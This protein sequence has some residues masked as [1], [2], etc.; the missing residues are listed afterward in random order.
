MA[1]II[2]KGT[3]LLTMFVAVVCIFV[4]FRSLYIWVG[5]VFC[6]C[7]RCIYGGA[8]SRSAL[9]VYILYK[10]KNNDDNIDDDILNCTLDNQSCSSLNSCYDNVLYFVRISP[11]TGC[12]FR[13]LLYALSWWCWLAVFLITPAC[14]YCTS[15]LPSVTRS[16]CTK[17]F[18]SRACFSPSTNSSKI[19]REL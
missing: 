19:L 15:L 4:V 17:T 18:P 11:T 6:P 13:S 7:N 16:F 3:T 12:V 1:S 2:V 14:F 9:C 10:K 5:V 8:S